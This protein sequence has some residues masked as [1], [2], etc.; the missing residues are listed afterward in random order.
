M[1]ESLSIHKILLKIL[2]VYSSFL[3]Y[4]FSFFFCTGALLG[5]RWGVLAF[6]EWR[7]MWPGHLPS[8]IKS[9]WSHAEPWPLHSV[10]RQFGTSNLITLWISEAPS[11]PLIGGKLCLGAV[12]ISCASSRSSNPEQLSQLQNTMDGVT[13]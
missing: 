13:S 6:S 1:K 2:C 4:L 7:V 5:T 9:P 11:E 10:S 12:C 3:C 8:L